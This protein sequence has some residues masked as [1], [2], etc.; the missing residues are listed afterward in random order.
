MGIL[1]HPAGSPTDL[2]CRDAGIAGR[3]RW[4]ESTAVIQHRVAVAG[5]RRSHFRSLPG[6]GN[7]VP[8]DSTLSSAGTCSDESGRTPAEETVPADQ[9]RVQLR[10]RPLYEEVR[11]ARGCHQASSAHPHAG[12]V[13]APQVPALSPP[14]PLGQGHQ[15]AHRPDARRPPERGRAA[16]APRAPSLLRPG[17][18]LRPERPPLHRRRHVRRPA[19][20]HPDEARGGPHPGAPPVPG[21]ARPEVHHGDPRPR[22]LPGH[23]HLRLEDPDRPAGEDPR[24][25]E[26]PAAARLHPVVVLPRRRHRRTPHEPG[27]ALRHHHQ[28][29]GRAGTAALF[30][31][32]VTSRPEGWDSRARTVDPD[33]F[34]SSLLISSH[35]AED[36]FPFV[37]SFS[38]LSRFGD[39]GSPTGRFPWACI[40]CIGQELRGFSLIA[41]RWK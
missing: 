11:H 13:Q 32:V 1:L 25:P 4:P 19:R 38:L 39:D 24:V 41:L 36:H 3:V 12:V 22:R 18:A 28:R 29:P 15:A 30:P 40:G 7:A 33:R 10:R 9:E 26:V 2:A 27:P 23:R 37:L 17:D 5:V 35:L 14:V 6:R 34:P 31:A 21:R 8:L 20:R 16:V